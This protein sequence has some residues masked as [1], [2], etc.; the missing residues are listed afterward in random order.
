M[1]NNN[2]WWGDYNKTHIINEWGRGQRGSELASELVAWKATDLV[3]R[4]PDILG[5]RKT[6]C[7]F[8][9]YQWN[10]R[11][12]AVMGRLNNF[13]G[14]NYLKVTV[15]PMVLYSSLSTLL[16]ELD[17]S[18]FHMLSTLLVDGNGVW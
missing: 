9:T 4:F 15:K 13:R 1:R 5:A 11:Y 17:C 16:W 6:R 3:L 7:W 18:P 2:S 10:T 12:R 8:R 14:E